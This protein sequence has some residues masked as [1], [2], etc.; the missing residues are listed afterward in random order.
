MRLVH[1]DQFNT[2][3]IIILAFSILLVAC[4]QTTSNE[5]KIIPV[6]SS[7]FDEF[8]VPSAQRHVEDA[9]NLAREWS[10]DAILIGVTVN[11]PPSGQ[12]EFVMYSFISII[13][14]K[15]HLIFSYIADTVT[16]SI[17]DWGRSNDGLNEIELDRWLMDSTE[18]FETAQHN[19][20]Q[21]HLQ[22]TSGN[23][24]IMLLLEVT[25][26]NTLVWRVSYRSV[27][28]TGT[29]YIGIDAET[30]VFMWIDYP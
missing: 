23:I 12:Q 27:D 8:I 14:S 2:L 29:M 17:Y 11:V 10:S 24:D 16:T 30:G 28:G 7:K 26:D 4:L 3:V 18:A 6:S 5:P 20:G 15:E 22:N 13:N 25:K 1:S 21:E 9:Y 19:G